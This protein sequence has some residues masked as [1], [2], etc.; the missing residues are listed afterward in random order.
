MPILA[1]VS[2]TLS[3][4]LT[5]V[6]PGPSTRIARSRGKRNIYC[7][8]LCLLILRLLYH[9]YLY[10][11]LYDSPSPDEPVCVLAAAPLGRTRPL[12]VLV[13]GATDQPYLGPTREIIETL[14]GYNVAYDIEKQ[15]PDSR[16]FDSKQYALIIFEHQNVYFEMPSS[17]R[18]M[19]DT[20]CRENNIGMLLFFKYD[21]N[22]RTKLQSVGMSFDIYKVNSV[23]KAYAFNTNA[24]I[25]KITRPNSVITNGIKGEFCAF[26]LLR[27]QK[28]HY[29]NLTFGLTSE[30]CVSETKDGCARHVLAVEDVGEKDGVRRLF[31]GQTF[32]FW[33][34]HLMFIDAVNFLVGDNKVIATLD[35]AISIEIDDVFRGLRGM[36][37]N[38]SDVT[39]MR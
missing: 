5:R 33:A 27:T 23:L 8:L 15:L 26:D 35:R 3:R 4:L 31:L 9:S 7:S 6:T 30:K 20:Y 28:S 21:Q 37:M 32:D 11:D 29:R 1:A 13:D 18:K 2:G 12:L 17:D 24:S 14:E 22:A 38:T 25:Y 19:L 36:R 16:T 39:V 34:T 10:L